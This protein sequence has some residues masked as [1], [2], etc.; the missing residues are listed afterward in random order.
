MQER[1][2]TERIALTAYWLTRGE[3]F[4]VRQLSERLGTTPRGARM[5]LEKMSLALP[6]A[7]LDN[8]HDPN[9]GAIWRICGSDGT[10]GTE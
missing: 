7:E 5:L 10:Y 1:L 9:A 2:P 8:P 3:G 4:T 6:L